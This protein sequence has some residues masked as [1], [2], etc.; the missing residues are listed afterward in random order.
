MELFDMEVVLR[1]HEHT[2]P[3]TI[4]HLQ[5]LCGAETQDWI[6]DAISRLA[7]P[8]LR[9]VVVL[10]DEIWLTVAGRLCAQRLRTQ[11]LP[12]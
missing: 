10:N 9:L 11:D 3:I 6:T 8:R 4:A 5:G 2:V 12:I 1:L 7:S